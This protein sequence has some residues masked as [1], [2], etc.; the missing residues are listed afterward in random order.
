MKRFLY[1]PLDK[2]I[3]WIEDVLDWAAWLADKYGYTGRHRGVYD[4]SVGSTWNVELIIGEPARVETVYD[5]QMRD[6]TVTFQIPR[7]APGPAAD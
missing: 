3:W 7:G 4:W 2:L 1:D 5:E 6:Y